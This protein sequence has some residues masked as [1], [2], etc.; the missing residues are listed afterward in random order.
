MRPYKNDQRPIKIPE[1]KHTLVTTTLDHRMM[2]VL[3]ILIVI[4]KFFTRG[5][6]AK[7]WAVLYLSWPEA[8]RINSESK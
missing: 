3:S 7:T 4:V 2:K 8:N 5:P 1:K 6:K